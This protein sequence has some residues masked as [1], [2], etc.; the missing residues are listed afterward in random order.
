M[1][2]LLNLTMCL[3]ITATVTQF[4]AINVVLEYLLILY[5]FYDVYSSFISPVRKNKYTYLHI[6]DSLLAA[7]GFQRFMGPLAHEAVCDFSILCK[8]I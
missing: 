3:H 6:F 4:M 8:H 2:K 5:I 7:S 1:G